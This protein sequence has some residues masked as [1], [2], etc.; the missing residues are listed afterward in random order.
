MRRVRR[1]IR[2]SP[3]ALLPL[4]LVIADSEAAAPFA[5]NTNGAACCLKGTSDANQFLNPP[6]GEDTRFFQSPGGQINVGLAFMRPRRML[7]FPFSLLELRTVGGIESTDNGY[8]LYATPL[9]VAT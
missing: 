9:T 8:P 7:E 6:L 2:L 1:L 3:I 4:L 5:T